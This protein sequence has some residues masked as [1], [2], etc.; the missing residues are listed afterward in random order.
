MTLLPKYWQRS[1]L[2]RLKFLTGNLL[3]AHFLLAIIASVFAA[4]MLDMFLLALLPP[5]STSIEAVVDAILLVCMTLPMLYLFFYCPL[6]L[7]VNEHKRAMQALEVE[8]QRLFALLSELPAYVFLKAADYSIRFANRRFQE[9]FGDPAGK[10]CYEIIF[11]RHLPCEDCPT[12]QAFG[13]QGPLEWEW[14]HVDGRTYQVYDY[15][16]TDVDG[17][18][19]V[20][21]LGIDITA[22]KR[23]TAELLRH[24]AILGALCAVTEKFLQTASLEDSIQELLQGLGQAAEVSRVY[25]FGKYDDQVASLVSCQRYAWVAAGSASPI[26]P[27]EPTAFPWQACGMA[28]WAETLGQGNIIQGQVKDFPPDERRVLAPHGIQ[29]I[30]VAP[31][32]VGRDWWGCIGFY[33]HLADRE[34][35]LAETQALKAAAG[36]LGSLLYRKQVEDQVL[37]YQ[38]RLKALISELSLTEERE[39][40]RLATDLHDSIAQLLALIKLKVETLHGAAPS[41]DLAKGLDNVHRLITEVIQDTRSLIFDLSPPVLYQFGLEAAIES[42]VDRL[43]EQHGL[44]IVLTNDTQPRPLSEDMRGLLFRAVRELL[45]NVVKHA[46]ARQAW[47]T[48]RRDGETIYITVV[49][50]GVGFDTAELDVRTTYTGRFGLFSIAERLR[51]LGG[52]C[53]IA[54]TPGQGTRATL[55]APLQEAE[56]PVKEQVT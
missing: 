54:S 9:H 23:A 34:W 19:L 8:R 52:G 55:V 32:F 45:L 43:Q 12:S 16:Y 50:D 41:A 33:E 18:P 40:H 28:R 25:V 39:R 6:A 51:H 48:L 26:P 30:L 38:Q 17:S 24:D 37:T 3:P 56:E 29:S 11:G 20:L 27:P 14:T 10:P 4:E 35:S 47:V 13:E 53:T 44:D 7:H 46:R 31:I 5:L 36:T 22:R 42:L 21:E 49:D 2:H 15:P 1:G